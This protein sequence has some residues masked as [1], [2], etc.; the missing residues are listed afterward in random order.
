MSWIEIIN[1]NLNKPEDKSRL[2]NAFKKVRS[3][4]ELRKNR[5]IKASLF[6]NTKSST[7]WSIHLKREY[8]APKPF[9]TLVGEN[10]A[11]VFRSF[12]DVDHTVWKKVEEATVN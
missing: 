4:P 9:K 8:S 3:N 7:K 12:G 11:G 10:I 2:R 6:R 1:L 5:A